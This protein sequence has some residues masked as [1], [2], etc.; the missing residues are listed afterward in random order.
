MG[1]LER[2]DEWAAAAQKREAPQVDVTSNVVRSIQHVR[3]SA[4]VEKPV[5]AIAAA[6]MIAA[7]IALGAAWQSWQTMHDPLIQW[8]NTPNYLTMR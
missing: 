1:E 6:A 2:F 7:S 3:P 4:S 8:F 5:V